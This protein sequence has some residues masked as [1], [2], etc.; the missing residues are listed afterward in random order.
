MSD[1]VQRSHENLASASPT[2]REVVFGFDNV[3]ITVYESLLDLIKGGFVVRIPKGSSSLPAFVKMQPTRREWFLTVHRDAPG[4]RLVDLVRHFWHASDLDMSAR[5]MFPGQ[6]DIP[7]SLAE[8]VPALSSFVG[9]KQSAAAATAAAAPATAPL[10]ST[11]PKRKRGV[12]SP[13][14]S[15]TNAT[16]SDQSPPKNS[17][18]PRKSNQRATAPVLIGYAAAASAPS[19]ASTPAPAP[20]A[21]IPSARPAAERPSNAAAPTSYGKDNRNFSP[22]YLLYCAKN[23]PCRRHA[24]GTC[25]LGAQCRF[26]HSPD[27]INLPPP[28]RRRRPHH[29]RHDRHDR[30]NRQDRYHPDRY[31]RVDRPAASGFGIATLQQ[32][33]NELEG[34]V[35]RL[36]D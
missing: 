6:S 20:S 22:Q 14:M 30:Y 7:K 1:V 32:R 29:D 36:M 24:L 17:P 35:R 4:C 5:I 23:V 13:E 3:P 18:P 25:N 21:I 8:Q 19:P 26:S 34:I 9:I 16:P 15:A 33:V 28:P 2:A 12:S 27:V 31:L 11:Q 10:D